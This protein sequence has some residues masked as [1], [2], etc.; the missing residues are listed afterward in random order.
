MQR[1][2]HVTAVG[3]LLCSVTLAAH[4]A[5][6]PAAADVAAL[7]AELVQIRHDYDLRLAAL[8]AQLA[9]A[10]G[11][12]TGN[13]L[14]AS[15]RATSGDGGQTNAFLPNPQSDTLPVPQSDTAGMATADSAAPSAT[16][17]GGNAFNPDIGLN[18]Q[19]RYG[20]FRH[21]AGGRTIRGF[22]LG[23]DAGPG[24]QGLSLAE[25]E[26]SLSANVDNRFYGFANLAFVQ[27]GGTSR[28]E[29]EE[30]YLQTT[31][32][33]DGFTARAGQFFANVG[34]QNTRHSHA[35]DFVDQPL[36]Y[37]VLLGG[38]YLDPGVRVSWLAPTD[39]FIELGAEGFRGDRFPAGGAAR[40][41]VGATNLYA[42]F[43]G[44][45][46]DSSAWQGGIAWLA[47]QPRQRQY[48]AADGEITEFS[49]DSNL[50]VADLVWKWAPNGNFNDRNITVQAEWLHRR[51]RGRLDLVNGASAGS[52]RYDG[53]QDGWYVTGIVQFMP[54]WRAGLRYD[55]LDSD[56]AVSG[57]ATT[58]I[59][60]GKGPTARR[61]SAMLDFSNSEFS[62]LRL[63]YEHD[64]ASARAS[65]EIF[66]QYI[67]SLGAHGAHAF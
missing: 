1:F 33:P 56:N 9:A 17:A 8:E 54:R 29:V 42:K 49:G 35:W 67:M 10:G 18:L 11:G 26:L 7:R 46:S 32:L 27:D 15:S 28:V 39:L 6:P 12:G 37:E 19:G 23:P 57:L 21:V 60:G 52:G 22:Q 41:G 44:D 36:A 30:V 45:L 59:L 58:T 53:D 48:E 16:A 43:G 25:S 55:Q 24:E 50:L 2:R 4:G 20:A 3:L 14:A 38:Q 66:L 40:D 5:T 62:R 51:E 65:D 31:A 63:Q 47:A 64:A 61:Y 34:Y 13:T